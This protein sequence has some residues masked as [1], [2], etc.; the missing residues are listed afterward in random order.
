MMVKMLARRL[1]E[2]VCDRACGSG[3][4]LSYAMREVFRFIDSRWADADD[5]A[6]QRKDYAQEKLIGMD[7]DTRL[8]RVAK[9][10]MI[11]ENDGRSGIH[12]ADSL[13]Y[14]AWD[15]FLKSFILGRPLKASEAN[16]T[17]LATARHPNDG[18]DVILTNP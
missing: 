16:G 17:R 18:V 4:F 2:S 1:D 7:N 12:Y 5:R 10:Y 9:A 13:D 3:G 8:V 6:E 11:M 15:R 14:G